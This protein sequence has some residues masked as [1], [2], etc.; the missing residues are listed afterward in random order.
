MVEL[1]VSVNEIHLNEVHHIHRDVQRDGNH[2]LKD[3]DR[4]QEVQETCEVG[5]SAV[6]TQKQVKKGNGGFEK[7]HC[8][9]IVD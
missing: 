2:D 7:P 8:K 6:R 5:L 4:R 9:D 1:D 3:D